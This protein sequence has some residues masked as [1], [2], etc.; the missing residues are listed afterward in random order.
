MN[1][2][3]RRIVAVT[4]ALA[5]S[6]MLTWAQKSSAQSPP[7]SLPTAPSDSAHIANVLKTRALVYDMQFTTPSG[8]KFLTSRE[9]GRLRLSITNTSEVVVRNVLAKL[10]PI[11]RPI[12][13][14]FNDS[15]MVGD[16]P[17][18]QSQYAIFYLNTSESVPDQVV[19][20][21]VEVHQQVGQEPDPRLLT[22]ETKARRQ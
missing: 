6:A 19:T 3:V 7:G 5:C 1:P 17:P 14:T 16:I 11:D 4:M 9:T 8:E 15:I 20:I 2:I 12:G 22:F 18:G 10:V 21:G 13:V